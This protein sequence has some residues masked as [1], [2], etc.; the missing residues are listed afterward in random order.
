MGV[1]QQEQEVTHDLLL[2]GVHQVDVIKPHACWG[3]VEWTGIERWCAIIPDF[4]W[5]QRMAVCNIGVLGIE[6][7]ICDRE[8][9]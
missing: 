2:V 5:V 9:L 7:Y 6:G 1:Q 8:C 4:D 3:H